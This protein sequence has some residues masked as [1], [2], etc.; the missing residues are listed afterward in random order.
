MSEWD[1][2]WG[3]SGQD[4]EDAMSSGAT[5]EEWEYIAREQERLERKR[6]WGTLKSKRDNGDISREEFK[7]QRELIFGS[8][9]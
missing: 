5:R 2:L 8:P 4:L 6:K 9:D 7:R 3:L 1:F